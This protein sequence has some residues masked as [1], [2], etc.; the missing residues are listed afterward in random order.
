[1]QSP[2]DRFSRITARS[3]GKRR[4]RRWDLLG[5]GGS[6][7]GFL[8]V[9]ALVFPFS[10]G[11]ASPS[12]PLQQAGHT[13]SGAD[14]RVNV[15]LVG[16]DS[17]EGQQNLSD[18]LMVAQIEEGSGEV[19]LLSVP[20][21]FYVPIPNSREPYR[22]INTA[23]AIGG[24]RLAAQSVERL[25]GLRI[26]H[27]ASVDFKGF[28]EAIDAVGG[29]P[30][31]V[32]KSYH[33]RGYSGIN[34]EPGR[35][36]LSGEQALAYVRFRHNSR[37]DLGRIERQQKLLA[38]MTDRFISPRNA[39]KAPELASVAEKHVE[40]DMSRAQMLGLAGKL[41][42]A[43]RRGLTK[44]VT[45]KGSPASLGDEGSVLIPDARKNSELLSSFRE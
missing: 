38:A 29:V 27:Y 37:G 34:L 25:T 35:Q 18:V 33:E 4:V 8:V 16:Y 31:E 9:V 14:E 41:Y 22:K 13:Q 36:T 12:Y 7:L 19:R 26:D 11:G 20:R 23:Y 43:Q 42:E 44:S 5:V 15:L 3:S 21:D 30:V 28:T 39:I 2:R 24:P 10:G 6:L 1:M 32:E 40:T 45:L 17:R